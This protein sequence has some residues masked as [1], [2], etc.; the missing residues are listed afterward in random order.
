MPIQELEE[1]YNGLTLSQQPRG[2]DGQEEDK[3]TLVS[4]RTS[5]NMSGHQLSRSC[6]PGSNHNSQP[7]EASGGGSP[8]PTRDSAAFQFW[9]ALT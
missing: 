7:F 4:L 9:L 3:S 8:N 1:A 5:L 6:F 2:A